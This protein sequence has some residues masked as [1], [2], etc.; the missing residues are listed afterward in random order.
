MPKYDVSCD[1]KTH[2]LSFTTDFVREAA[3]Q[4]PIMPGSF[5][6]DL[7]KY[8]SLKHPHSKRFYTQVMTPKQILGNQ[9]SFVLKDIRYTDKLVLGKFFDLISSS[10]DWCLI[11]LFQVKIK[12][13]M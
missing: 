7:E 5:G 4:I 1:D 9:N 11:M 2:Q 8:F 6:G 10:A 13:V 12:F 3:F